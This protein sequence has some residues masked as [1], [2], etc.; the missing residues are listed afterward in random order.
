MVVGV[1][2]VAIAVPAIVT[3]RS[4]TALLHNELNE[5][6]VATVKTVGLE[7]SDLLA[8]GDSEALSRLVITLA[9]EDPAVDTALIADRHGRV[10]AHSDPDKEGQVLAD[11]VPPPETIVRIERPGPSGSTIL[12]VTGPVRVS[13][14]AWGSFRIDVPMSIID[15]EKRAHILRILILGGAVLILGAAGAAWLAR[16]I[17]FPVERLAMMAQEVA[18]GRLEVRSGVR[19]K[20]EIGTLAAAFDGMAA[21]LAR[22]QEELRNHSRSLEKRVEERTAELSQSQARTRAI[23]ESALDGI[24]TI[25]QAGRI[26][27]F[28]PAAERTFGFRRDEAV[29]REM[30]ELIVPAQLREQHRAGLARV[31]GGGEARLLGQRVE[32]TALRADG[33]E[34]P[35]EMALTRL[36]TIGS[37]CFT[38]HLRDITERKRAE[39]EL[40]R[41][42]DT[43]EEAARVKS[44]F[45]ANMSHEIRTPMNGVIGMTGLLLDTDLSREQ[46]EYANLVR[47]SADALLTIINDIL[48]FSKIE[49]GKLELEIVDFDL[50]TLVEEVAEL[51]A[52]SIQSKGLE[53]CCLIHSDTPQAVGGDPGRLR[54]ILTNLVGNAV[55]FTERGEVVIR[56]RVE[57]ETADEVVG[58]FEVSDTGIGIAKDAQGRLF[59]SF[60]QADGSTTRKYGGTGLGLAICRQLVRMMGGDI[61]VVSAPGQG[62][63]FWFTARLKKRPQAAIE[64]VR[65]PELRGLRVLCVDD[66][67]TNRTLLEHQIGA[68]G[69]R[70]DTAPD[71]PA[72]LERLRQARLEK[73]PYELVVLDMQMPGMDGL[74]VAGAIKTDP[75]GARPPLVM[76][77]S[78]GQRGQAAAARRAGISGFLTKP[79]RQS[80]L[81]DCIVTVLGLVAGAGGAPADA[82]LVTGHH[83]KERSSRI[84]PRL[85]VAEDNVVNQM[86][87]VRMLE[88]LGYRADVVA[89]G[90][91][92][93]EALERI[94]YAMVFMDCQMP[95]MDGY[96]ATAAIRKREGSGR[97]TPIIAMTANAMQGDKERCLAAGMDDYVSKPVRSENLAAALGRWIRH[98]QGPAV[99]AAPGK[100]TGAEPIDLETLAGFRELQDGDAPDIVGELIDL[101]LKDSKRRFSEIERALGRADAPA[102]TD[103]AHALKG[104]SLNL[105]ARPLGDLCRRIE[106]ACSQGSIG[107]AAGL[108]LKLEQELSRVSRALRSHRSRWSAPIRPRP[109]RG[110]KRAEPHRPRR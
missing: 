39:E 85:L 2:V 79:V 68:W 33:T 54:Q 29:G 101:Y 77:T 92:A 66:N 19:S 60:S 25:D 14:E 80:S 5:R 36:P 83:L 61:G 48:D 12:E 6:S 8:A 52:A 24:I 62:S 82:P 42:R 104:S 98:E 72:G 4:T 88:K 89:D 28:N 20:D 73:D 47:S 105:G 21:Q 13:G 64:S 45:L 86:V 43:A 75:L 55:K 99:D 16:S 23:I 11:L 38:G 3:I 18:R 40:L 91:E 93:V 34:F 59:Q 87:A 71:G 41:A 53:I 109:A 100:A 81:Y 57:S 102:L 51:V 10:L 107:T 37:P 35:V 74:Q 76:L 27:D 78:V 90:R 31:A 70:V 32:I 106:E 15:A 17:A 108:V 7:A 84:R 30:A 63:T 65:V 1:L 49:A 94:P 96:E 50:R 46:R 58:R 22:D 67:A 26:I 95:D 110:G 69:M 97:R 103:A 56:C 44:Q 9:H